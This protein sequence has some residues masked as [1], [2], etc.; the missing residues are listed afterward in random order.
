MGGDL[1]TE[2][3]LSAYRAGIFPWPVQGI[4]PLLW[5]SPDPRCLLLPGELQVSRRLERRIRSGR[6][7]VRFD[8]AAEEIIAACADR[9]DGTWITPAMAEAYGRLFREGHVRCAGSW[10][11]GRLVGGIYGVALGGIFF[12]E[13]MFFRES[14]AS[15]VALVALARSRGF[16][17][18]DCQQETSHLRSLGARA[19]RRTEF[20]QRL[21]EALP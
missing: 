3:L 11:G 4:E 9:P 6:F 12:G 10:R 19:V 20:L 13:S 2:R 21:R 1:S 14:D 8:E 16:R 18:I 5:W 17:F 7:E 15:K